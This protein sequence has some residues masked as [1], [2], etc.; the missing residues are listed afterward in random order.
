MTQDQHNEENTLREALR[1]AFSLGQTYWQQADSE[2][3]SQHRK[4]DE[5]S[6]KF[7]ELVETTV[8]HLQQRP[9]PVREHAPAL[10]ERLQQKCSDWG[11]YWRAPDA[12]GVVLTQ[13]QALEL[14]RD[15]LGVEVEFSS[16]PLTD[17]QIDALYLSKLAGKGFDNIA[18]AFRAMVRAIEAAHG[19][20]LSPSLPVRE[21]PTGWK[22]VPVEPTE[23]ML[24][25]G[26]PHMDGVSHLG[27]AWEAMLASSPSVQNSTNGVEGRTK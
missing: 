7:S 22:L 2:Y 23:E 4:A 11:T 18:V 17:D 21:E 1:R 10:T 19:I 20:A 5:T 6:A 13:E 12:H 9:L 15:A 27:D 24:A 14:L 3:T 16:G 26:E 8:A 25:A